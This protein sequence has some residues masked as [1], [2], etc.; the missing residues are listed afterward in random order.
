MGGGDGGGVFG[1]G[2]LVVGLRGLRQLLGLK[3]IP[4][5]H[6]SSL[7]ICRWPRLRVYNWKLPGDANEP[8]C[9]SSLYYREL[10]P[11]RSP[12]LAVSSN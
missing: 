4:I 10:L 6:E 1:E 9:S 12:D 2:G 11:P 7:I 8:S 5:N 3:R